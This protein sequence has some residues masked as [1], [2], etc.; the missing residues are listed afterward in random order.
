MTNFPKRP[1]AALAAIVLVGT[2]YSIWGDT[3]LD[4]SNPLLT[5]LPH[6]LHKT[7]YF[8]SKNN[9]VNVLFT[10]RLWGWTTVA[11]FLLYGT[12]PGPI[13]RPRRLL[14]YTIE[15]MVWAAFTMWFFG[16]S[17]FDR[18]TVS[19][20][21]ECVV[22]LPTGALVSVPEHLCY[23]KSTI[24]TQTHPDLFAASL[25]LPGDGWKQVPRIRRGH[26][27]SGHLFLLTMTILFLAEQTQTTFKY[28]RSRA[29]RTHQAT[30]YHWLAVC[31]AISV[32]GLAYFASWTTS[33]YFHSPT[34]KISGFCKCSAHSE[35][36]SL[37]LISCSTWSRWICRHQA[38]TPQLGS[39]NTR[40]RKKLRRRTSYSQI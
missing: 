32:L 38:S 29:A 13:Q 21:G 4:T 28:S 12:S 31:F 11:F 25:V 19:T 7:H 3:Y 10:K 20:G 40:I 24:T 22:H 8:A 5:H 39:T 15:T 1:L 30:L 34:E 16:P 18:L 26:D 14:K 23:S 2:L 33:V 35:N 17:L 37:I 9:V 27:V 6:P 36:R